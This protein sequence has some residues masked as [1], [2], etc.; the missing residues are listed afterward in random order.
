MLKGNLSFQKKG[1][2][3]RFLKSTAI[4]NERGVNINQELSYR[5]ILSEG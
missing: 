4:Y 2:I 3:V 1:E 5:Y